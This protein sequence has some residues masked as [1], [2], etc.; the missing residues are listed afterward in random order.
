M[1]EYALEVKTSE[2]SGLFFRPNTAETAY[3]QQITQQ[4]A[5]ALMVELGKPS[6]EEEYI[7]VYALAAKFWFEW[8]TSN[9]GYMDYTQEEMLPAVLDFL[10]LNN[11][12]SSNPVEEESELTW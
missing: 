7:Q 12:T 8:N 10:G 9:P 2:R 6:T 4:R 3:P 1:N 11:S 5:L